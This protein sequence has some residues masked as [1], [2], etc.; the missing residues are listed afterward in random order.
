VSEQAIAITFFVLIIALTLGITAWAARLNKDTA[1]HYVAGGEIKGWQNGLA[2][3]GDYLSAA[4]FLGIAGAIAL[5]GFSGFFFSIGYLVAYLVV[6]LLVAE[7]LR[8]LGKYTFA[9]ML[10]ARFNVSSV[11]SVA[12]L[13]TIAISTF[14]MIA[15]LVGAGALITLLLGLPYWLS[16]IIIGVL[17]TI[18]IVAG[19]MVATTWIQIV[20]AVLL[21]AG[22]LALSIIVLANYGFN[23]VALFNAV[24]SEL[25]TG[26][27]Q[28]P[29]PGGL[30]SGIDVVSLNVALVFGTAG[31]PHIL[32]R[33]LTVPDARTARKSIIWAT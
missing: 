7:P 5:T 22:T 20:K 19:G 23:P 33:F 29:A 3:S 32:M 31:L 14:Y 2:I 9:D 6:L 4:S 15:Q 28:P 10:A 1:H 12:A 11:R 25:G 17:M 24:D 18:Y 13:S 21:I 8:N 30:L 16:V 27:V 26:M